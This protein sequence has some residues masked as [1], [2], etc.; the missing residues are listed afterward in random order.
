VQIDPDHLIEGAHLMGKL[1]G[2]V[3]VITASTRSI[4]RGIAEA[5]HAE[6]ASVV[7]SGRSAEKGKK[8]IEEMG[9]GDR[10]H[11]IAADASKQADVEALVDGT[12]DKF[13]RV[14]I[15]VPNAGGVA[16][17][18]PVAMMSDEEWQFELDININQTFWM[19]RRALKYMVP[20]QF[21]RVI[22]MSSM[23]GKISTMAV[24][25][26]IANKHAI[27]GLMKALAK[28]V[29]TQGITANAV[30]PGF[31]PTDMFYESGPATVEAMGLPDLDA[32]AAVMYSVTA[33]Q[34]PNTVEEVG[35]ACVLL[36]SDLGAG[37]TG[38]AI[39]VDGGA[40]PY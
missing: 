6:G 11:F 10:L 4:G 7:L 26:Y 3:A 1:D 35:A 5:F 27:I 2:R 22:G 32:L 16:N 33:I 40:S 28:E 13:G 37:I 15:V 20:Q 25:G 36:A 30:C 14:D 31:V 39:N 24:P 8:A 9:G 12:V 21:G 34:R 17:T 38:T 19:S 18:A 23:Y 29:G